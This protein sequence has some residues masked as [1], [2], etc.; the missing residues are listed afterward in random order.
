MNRRSFFSTLGK[1]V[2]GFTILPPATTYSRV[3]RATKVAFPPWII[4]WKAVEFKSLCSQY[5]R[6]PLI[7]PV[8][9]RKTCEDLILAITGYS[10][11]KYPGKNMGP[12]FT[13][14]DHA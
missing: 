5:E 12:L 11:Q 4:H 13:L 7:V 3:W 10:N 2:V 1:A 6:G 9:D 14:Y 8:G